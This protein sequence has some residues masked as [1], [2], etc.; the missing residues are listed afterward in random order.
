MFDGLKS[1]AEFDF[2][3]L[4]EGGLDDAGKARSELNGKLSRLTVFFN[5][6]IGGYCAP[7]LILFTCRGVT[8]NLKSVFN[9][10]QLKK[11]L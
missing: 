1:L 5:D 11:W 9:Q 7:I 10:L 8:N 2:H 6:S 4:Q 3:D